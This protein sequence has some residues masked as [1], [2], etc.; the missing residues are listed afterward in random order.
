MDNAAV[1]Q[2]TVLV[3]ATFVLAMLV[4]VVSLAS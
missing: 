1:S 4:F 3:R 2:D